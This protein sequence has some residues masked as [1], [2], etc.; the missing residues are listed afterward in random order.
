MCLLQC[1]HRTDEDHIGRK[2]T[3]EAA[4]S[5]VSTETTSFVVYR[6]TARSVT[7]YSMLIT[8]L[9]ARSSSRVEQIL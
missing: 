9:P 4:L 6:W 8:S 7:M 2:T 3:T 5:A 1:L